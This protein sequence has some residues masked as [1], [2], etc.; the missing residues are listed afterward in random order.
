M[1]FCNSCPAPVVWATSKNGNKMPLNPARVDPFAQGAFV[2]IGGI[3]LGPKDAIAH[4]MTTRQCGE[5]AARE[6]L[7]DGF[8]WRI[9]HFATCPNAGSHR[10]ARR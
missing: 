6:L 10:K 4:V 3:A 5:H 7:S 1:S 2:V 8:T 9:S